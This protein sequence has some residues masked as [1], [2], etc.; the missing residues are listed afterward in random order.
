LAR[1]L[2]LDWDHNQLHVIAATISRGTVR[3]QHA[4][5][6]AEADVPSPANAEALGKVLRERLKAAGI[7]PAPVLACLGRDRVIIKDIR[8]PN[9]P[10]AE[11]P[12][13]VRFQAMKELTEPADEVIID[14]TAAGQGSNATE[15]RAFALIIR[16][17]LLAA[18]QTLCHSAG[19]KLAGFTPRLLGTI[20]CFKQLAGTPALSPAPAAD[21]TVGLLTLGERW[22][23]F[24]VLRG[25][26][27]VFARSLTVGPGLAGEVKRN[28]AFYAGQSAQ[29]PV[30]AVYLA[31]TTDVADLRERLQNLLNLDVFLFDPF[32][33]GDRPP[34]LPATGR[35]GFAGALGLLC[36]QASGQPLPINFVKVK[37]TVR[38][39]QPHRR[40]YMLAACAV[41][42]ALLGGG[43]LWYSQ[44][45]TLDREAAELLSAK[46]DLDAQLAVLE[47]DDKRIK[48]LT[49]W[50][51]S[52]V[53]W[54]DE[55]YDL[56][57][58]FPDDSS[59][60]LVQLM[61]EPIARTA[62]SKYIGKLA[63]KGVATE[64][65]DPVDKL[66]NDMAKD[67]HLR[68]EPK[69]LSPNVGGDRRQYPQQFTTKVDIE[70]LQPTKYV[71]RIPEP[72]PLDRR[73]RGRQQGN[74]LDFGFF[75]VGQ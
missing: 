46:K 39:A 45:L 27:P 58:R 49:E 75:G 9:V 35:S 66:M 71:R 20:A 60:R 44:M 17:E 42:A 55:L 41:V 10:L 2:A 28:M 1:F 65:H 12:G 43:A 36:L 23:E 15:K 59:I 29:N 4:Q 32:A 11:E 57:D 8:Y 72:D 16:R 24:V 3:V 52:E 62:K 14:Y 56:T 73:N 5:V 37:E 33:A 70:R 69:F 21:A 48:A 50:T 34:N 26:A 22:A 25:G 47:D 61:G 40:L 63:L 31:G 18:Y 7:A 67:S 51:E 30:S 64:N 68:P 54:L 6:F 19:L 13:L 38:Q 53:V 74:P